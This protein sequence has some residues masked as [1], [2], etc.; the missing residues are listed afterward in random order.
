MIP[1]WILTVAD[2]LGIA[3]RVRVL[4]ATGGR[5]RAWV[6]AWSVR[7][8]LVRRKHIVVPGC[9]VGRPCSKDS[10]SKCFV[11]HSCF[12]EHWLLFQRSFNAR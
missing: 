3:S 2:G 11:L 9:R 1:S 7:H 8:V 6:V 10:G 5:E 12:P 4:S